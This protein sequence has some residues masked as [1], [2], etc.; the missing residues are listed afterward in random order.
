[1]IMFETTLDTAAV[2]N[3]NPILVDENKRPIIDTVYGTGIEAQTSDRCRFLLCGDFLTYRRK[4]VNTHYWYA[5]DTLYGFAA[6]RY[7]V[8]FN[9]CKYRDKK[10]YIRY[11]DVHTRNL[12]YHYI[13]I[14]A[15]KRIH[16]HDYNDLLRQEKTA[17]LKKLT[18]P[19][20]LTALFIS[21]S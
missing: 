8:K 11:R 2:Y 20:V 17:E 5:Y 3:L 12:Q 13:E 4:K 19:F 1:M 6:G 21:G 10:I 14:P 15:D 9:F 16:L 7:I 18:Q